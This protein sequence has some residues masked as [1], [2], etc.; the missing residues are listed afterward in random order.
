MLHSTGERNTLLKVTKQL[1]SS[2]EALQLSIEPIKARLHGAILSVFKGF[3][4]SSGFILLLIFYCP[5]FI[6][7]L[8]SITP[9]YKLNLAYIS[10][11]ISH[12]VKKG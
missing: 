5:F 8:I 6:K 10:I 7:N 2:K 3:I 11:Q 4:L 9:A 12:K 1:E